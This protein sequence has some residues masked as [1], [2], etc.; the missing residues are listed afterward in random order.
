MLVLPWFPD[1]WAVF[2]GRCAVSTPM[3]WGNAGVLK[4]FEQNSPAKPPR[5]YERVRRG[6]AL[7]AFWLVR[8]VDSRIS[9][10]SFVIQRTCEQG[11]G[12]VRVLGANSAASSVTMSPRTSLSA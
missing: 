3:T 2:G 6:F 1:F 11:T 7:I 9:A 12:C 8:F 5:S 4:S 10:L